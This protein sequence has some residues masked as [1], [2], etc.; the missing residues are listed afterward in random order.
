LPLNSPALQ[1]IRHLRDEA[2][3]FAVTYHRKL[4]KKESMLSVLDRVPGV[5]PKTKEKLLRKFGT[6]S[7]MQALSEENL[8]AHG[9]LSARV[10]R[11]LFQAFQQHV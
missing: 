4:H 7:K 3:R 5:G 1:L 2:H 8:I 6:V 10:A 11:N 9:G